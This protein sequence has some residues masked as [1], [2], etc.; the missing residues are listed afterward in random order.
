MVGIQVSQHLQTKVG[1]VSK[2]SWTDLSCGIK[3]FF[4]RLN[5]HTEKLVRTCWIFHFLEEKPEKQVLKWHFWG[6]PKKIDEFFGVYQ[7]WI[8]HRNIQIKVLDQITGRTNAILCD[9]KM[10]FRDPYMLLFCAI[11]RIGRD[12]QSQLFCF[13]LLLS[14]TASVCS[15]PFVLL[16]NIM[17]YFTMGK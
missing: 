8:L 7:T 9:K 16:T 2:I 3:H 17:L 12:M 4:C 14:F 1:G 5:F 11:T 10:P 13:H 6:V 15:L